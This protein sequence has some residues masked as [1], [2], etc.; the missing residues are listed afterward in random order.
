[1]RSTVIRCVAVLACLAVLALPTGLGFSI[2]NGFT[3]QIN[4]A[5]QPSAALGKTAERVANQ[6]PDAP[7]TS[8]GRTFRSRENCPAGKMQ[9]L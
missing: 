3:F 5:A 2:T 4:T 7:I 6:Q 8:A 1:M 9:L